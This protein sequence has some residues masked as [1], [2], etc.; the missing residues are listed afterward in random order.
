M[1]LIAA[2]FANGT[3][4]SEEETKANSMYPDVIAH[5]LP[6]RTFCKPGMIFADD[7]R[8]F[9]V[10]EGASRVQSLFTQNDFV[11]ETYG[12]NE[13]QLHTP[14]DATTFRGIPY[15]TDTVNDKIL[16]YDKRGAFDY[17]FRVYDSNQNQVLDAPIG[18][19][20]WKE[21][22]YIANNARGNIIV[23]GVDG[24]Y[25]FTINIEE[26]GAEPVGIFANEDRLFVT[27]PHKDKVYIYSTEGAFINSWFADDP[28]GIWVKDEKVYIAS[29]TLNT[30]SIY[31]VKGMKQAEINQSNMSKGNLVSPKG[32]AILGDRIHVS[33]MGTDSIEIFTL[34]LQHVGQFNA[35]TNVPDGS[36]TR[37]VKVETSG[38]NIYIVDS[39]RSII[40]TYKKTGQYVKETKIKSSMDVEIIEPSGVAVDNK[41]NFY[42]SDKGAHDIKVL[43]KDGNHI[44]TLSEKGYAPGKLNMP[45]D[46]C[47]SPT[48]EKIYVSDTGNHRI[49]VLSIEGD[50]I[51]RFG[52]FGHAPGQ[53]VLPAGICIFDNSILVADSGNNRISQFS[54]DGKPIKVIGTK[55]RGRGQLLSPMDCSVDASGKIYVADTY[56]HRIQAFDAETG[57]SW[58]FGLGGGPNDQYHMTEAVCPE[59]EHDP[60]A[61]GFFKF[62]MGIVADE[63]G[64]FVADTF[65]SR[66]QYVDY[67]NIYS[68]IRYTV[69]PTIVDFGVLPVGTTDTRELHLKNYSG[70]EIS[71]LIMIPDDV[72]WLTTRKA[73]F[74]GDK[75][76]IELMVD[77]SSMTNGVYETDIE[78]ATNKDGSND[79]QRVHVKL[80]VGD[81]YG[82]VFEVKPIVIRESSNRIDLPIKLNPQN[83]FTSTI[84]LSVENT[85]PKTYGQYTENLI[86]VEEDSP[87]ETTL[88]I[89][90]SYNITPG[91]YTIKIGAETPKLGYKVTANF[92]LIIT[93]VTKSIP[94]VVLGETF[95]AE[96]CI[97]C[98]YSHR[99]AERLVHEY[100]NQNIV[101]INYYVETTKVDEAHL[102]YPPADKRYKWYPGQGLPTTFFD[103]KNSVVGG[104]T[105]DERKMPPDDK[106]SCDKFSGTTFTY[107][108]Y[109]KEL[110]DRVPEPSQLSI[111]VDA[112][113]EDRTI[114]ANLE[115]ELI[116]S[117]G[118]VKNMALYVVLV[119][120]NIF[121]PALNT[122]EYHNLICREMYTGPLGENIELIEGQILT[123]QMQLRVPSYVELKN[124]GLVVWVQNNASKEVIQTSIVRFQNQPV[125]DS[126]IITTDE[127]NVKLEVA[128]EAELS[129]RITNTSTHH[130]DVE[131]TQKFNADGWDFMLSV[132]GLEVDET[133]IISLSPMETKTIIVNT[134]PPSDAEPG[135]TADFTILTSTEYSETKRT[136]ISAMTI[137]RL[138]P[139]FTFEPDKN[140]LEIT[141]G[142]SQEFEIIID[143]INEFDGP[144]TLTDCTNEP[145]IKVEFD[146]PH[147]VPPFKTTVK[148]TGGDDLQVEDYNVCIIA[149][150]ISSI[151]EEIE[152][153]VSLPVDV[154]Y[155]KLGISATPTKIISC[156]ENKSCHSAQIDI[157]INSP[158]PITE[159]RFS[160]RYD[161]S[162]LTVTH[163]ESGNFFSHNLSAFNFLDRTSEGRI[164]VQIVSDEPMYGKGKLCTIIMRGVKGVTK[165]DSSVEVC[166]VNA[167]GVDGKPLLANI[168]C[169]HQSIDI[170]STL[171]PPLLSVDIDDGTYVDQESILI[172]G[173][174]KTGDPDYP[175]IL[176]IN[177]R[178]VTVGTDGKWDFFATLREGR[179]S[180]VIIARDEAGT[181][182]AKRIVVNRDSTPPAIGI[183]NYKD[184][185]IIT[186]SIIELTGWVDEK[187]DVKINGK[188]V[189]CDKY[190]EFTTSVVLKQGENI[191]KLEA[192]DIMGRT[193]TVDFKL[194]VTSGMKIELWIGSKTMVVD[195]KQMTLPQEPVVS[196][197]PL[198]AE[199]A[200]NT[201][202]PIREVAETLYAKVDWD[203]GERKVTLTQNF[204]GKTKIVELW[205][206]KKTARIDGTEVWID[207]NHK[208]YPAIVN[209][210]TLLPLR[211][212]GETLGADVEWIA[213]ERKIVL[214]FPKK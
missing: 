8:I 181:S 187:A 141:Q 51:D 123:R 169:T 89:R 15:I 127:E 134:I 80:T 128:G 166:D 158:V 125:L 64:C 189:E 202:M 65:N 97:N 78:I 149:T 61:Q 48:G 115:L 205:I 41:G 131:C 102:Y 16:V 208:L 101:W 142:T 144:I 137:P 167:I 7:Y 95:T 210:K 106:M 35:E 94:R 200:N 88:S 192:T 53:L 156:S 50:Y 91:V 83:G 183:S 177:G 1:Q 191:I 37:P 81:S 75:E 174:A 43:D 114:N 49:Q 9:V 118:N 92:T 159:I 199:L 132:D 206:G 34:D 55:G 32:V 119:E 66:I 165:K 109:L 197:P 26:S 126:Y 193:V 211:F 69:S 130:I 186:D 133:T 201:Y 180:F 31:D 112:K 98:P 116:E 173:M 4:A 152:H 2:G 42:I 194:I 5:S 11:Y 204:Q 185:E 184:G 14:G 62:P 39:A 27:D 157:D 68:D 117:L 195:G 196:S 18:I 72:K 103:G 57:F 207:S 182:T 164:T 71:G 198:P 40:T 46:I 203:G 22:L 85:P 120:D 86:K 59:P 74:I 148:V 93:K 147:G 73:S 121:F 172:T 122:D 111:F 150:G 19:T 135:D 87:T 36:I 143:P 96:W 190:N 100:G 28:W 178:N 90:S 12:T 108:R 47:I 170:I 44:R 30:V 79:P 70:G 139:D 145:S 29:P 25:A 56:N 124:A 153:R 58:E 160:V 179:N 140:R 52:S 146:P 38:A 129:Y 162:V 6:A 176:S 99:A 168:G 155:A 154:M 212:V 20:T 136:T 3:Y 10:D 24:S 171:P 213:A 138:P 13:G 76:I 60:K 104:D 161:P 113:V 110:L 214:T 77:T 23:T 63:F 67:N 82:Y 54:L 209:N 17:E 105:P 107:L 175:L 45:S 151:G 188:P 163:H 84:A 33:S 21:K